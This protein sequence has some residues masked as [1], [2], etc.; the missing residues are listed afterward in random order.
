MWLVLLNEKTKFDRGESPSR[1]QEANGSKTVF[2]RKG[3][4]PARR[5]GGGEDPCGEYGTKLISLLRKDRKNAKAKGSG[6][7]GKKGMGRGGNLQNRRLR[8]A[9]SAKNTVDVSHCC[10]KGYSLRGGRWWKTRVTLLPSSDEGQERSRKRK[11]G[12]NWGQTRKKF[13]NQLGRRC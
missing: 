10:R 1:L 4:S 13:Q 3:G 5:G 8:K 11:K 9:I 7:S 2:C 12:Q 6:L